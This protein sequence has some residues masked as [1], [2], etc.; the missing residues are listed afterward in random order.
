MAMSVKNEET[1]RLARELAEATGESLTTAIT[2]SVRERLERLRRSSR[3]RAAAKAQRA[4]SLTRGSRE[5]W[6]P[7]LVGANYDDLLY[8]QDGLPK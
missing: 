8:D 6:H 7:D 5:L 2:V 3:D 4:M 1:E